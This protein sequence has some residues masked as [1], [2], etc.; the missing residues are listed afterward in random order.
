MGFQNEKKL[1]RSLS[2]AIEDACHGTIENAIKPFVADDFKFRGIG[3]SIL[4]L[5]T[6]CPL[7][8]VFR[9]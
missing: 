3:F 5:W 6:E 8:K 2:S 4:M 1:V 9:I 7:L